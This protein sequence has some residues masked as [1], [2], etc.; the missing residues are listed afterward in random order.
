MHR[1]MLKF[2]AVLELGL[3]LELGFVKLK[4]MSKG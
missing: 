1:V 2:T 4:V 3:M